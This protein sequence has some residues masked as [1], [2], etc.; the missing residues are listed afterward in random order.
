MLLVSGQVFQYLPGQ[1]WKAVSGT[2]FTTLVSAGDQLY[3]LVG[4][5]VF[6]YVPGQPWQAIS[7]AS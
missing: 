5:Q 2:G 1:P 6:Q 4:N 7:S 3:A